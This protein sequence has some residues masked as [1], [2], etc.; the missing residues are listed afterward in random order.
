MA[1]NEL[2]THKE[3]GRIEDHVEGYTLPS[4]IELEG[5][6]LRVALVDDGAV[7]EIRGI[8]VHGGGDGESQLS[9][10]RTDGGWRWCLR[11]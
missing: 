3:K 1:A 10:D 7:G 5:D 8:G 4:P 9:G 6:L 11:E 2:E